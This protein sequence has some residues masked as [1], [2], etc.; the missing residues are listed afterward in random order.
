MKILIPFIMLKTV[1]I[2]LLLMIS[3]NG[4]IVTAFPHNGKP[5]VIVPE[6]VQ[7]TECGGFAAGPAITCTLGHAPATG[8]GH[9]LLVDIIVE[10]T[11]PAITISSVVHTGDSTSCTATA[12]SPYT[13][14]YPQVGV[15]SIWT[16][17]NLATTGTAV[18]ITA[19]GTPGQSFIAF[20]RELANATAVD[21]HPTGAGGTGTTPT[22]TSFTTTTANELLHT[23]GLLSVGSLVPQNG[24][25]IP[26]NCPS[27]TAC[28][29][30]QNWEEQIFDQ[31]VTATGPYFTTFDN[32]A[33]WSLLSVSIK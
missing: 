15:L 26:A 11:S 3:L 31:I 19:S 20:V 8:S 17:F 18:V 14:T 23:N 10:S 1:I 28:S 5:T 21:Q 33:N 24:W 30:N 13:T 7:G 6:P 12:N 4:Q 27:P 29:Q 9:S 32:A 16:C 25:Y 22:G 2:T